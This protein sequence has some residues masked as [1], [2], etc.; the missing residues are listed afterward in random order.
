M[1]FYDT[2]RCEDS[3]TTTIERLRYSRVHTATWKPHT[4]THVTRRDG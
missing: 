4:T 3:A 2:Q 1:F